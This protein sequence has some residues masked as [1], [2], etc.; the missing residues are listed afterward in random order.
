MAY[1]ATSRAPRVAARGRAAAA[2]IAARARS[3]EALRVAWRAFA[4]SRLGIL[5]VAVYSG[6]ATGSAGG[7][8]LANTRRFDEPA[9]TRPLGGFGDALFSPLAH[10]DA[11]WFINIAGS[12]YPDADS[13]RT[14]FFPLYPLLSRGVGELGGGSRGAILI[15]AYAVSLAALLGA[16]YL[17]Y[18]LTELELGSDVA[19]PTLLLLCVFPASLFF[20]APYSESVFLLASVGAFFAARTGHWAWA[21]AAASA[22]SGT[23]SAGIL[24]LLPLVLL[25]LYGPRADRP[26]DSWPAGSGWR[27]GLRPRYAVRPDA[28]WLALAP[29][30]LVAYAGYL[31]VAH[32]DALAF[33]SAQEAWSREFAGPLSGVWQGAVAAFDGARQ[34]LSG[35]RE[36]VYFEQ[37]AGDPFRIAA[38]NLMLFASLCFAA[39]ATLGVLRRLP[40]AYGAY[41]VA[42][43][44]LP[45]SYP[46]EPQ[47]LMSLPR[48]LVVLFP[49]FMWLA[50]ACRERGLV[51][52]VAAASAVGLGV[53]VTQFVSWYFVA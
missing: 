38:I 18:R 43:L 11:V 37:A 5:L 10:W 8:T 9:L 26:P 7:L 34:V 47:P 15:G 22:A 17:L 51:E 4:W 16:L 44:M 6:L 12:G 27:N 50:L 13:P 36:T 45:L 3:S 48:F 23:R 14:A 46:V 42:A 39:V 2:A 53:F 24:L 52:R 25:Y 29:L 19:G 20:G 35:S 32:G 30:G 41:V 33:A 1:E 31:G 49:L 40:F 28:A 21:G